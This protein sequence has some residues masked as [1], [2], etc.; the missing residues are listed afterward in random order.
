MLQSV[1]QRHTITKHRYSSRHVVSP[2]PL[3][4]MPPTYRGVEDRPACTFQGRVLVEGAVG[5]DECRRVGH[6]ID[7]L[8]YSDSS[9]SRGRYLWT[10]VD[11]KIFLF[12]HG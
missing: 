9:A 3:Q 5:N 4:H 6:R 11:S 2:L 8:H 7:A 10:S 12:D 1:L